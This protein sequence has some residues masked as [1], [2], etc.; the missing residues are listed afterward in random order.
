MHDFLLLI[1]DGDAVLDDALGGQLLHRGLHE[2]FIQ[3][4]STTVTENLMISACEKDQ[5]PGLGR[6]QPP[7]EQHGCEGGDG[8]A[9]ASVKPVCTGFTPFMHEE[10]LGSFTQFALNFH[11]QKKS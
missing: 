1:L 2:A 8:N 5:Q 3:I 10:C 7:Q 11:T 6:R 9:V 4:I